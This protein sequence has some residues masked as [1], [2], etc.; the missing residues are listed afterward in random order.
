MRWTA[1][2]MVLVVVGSCGGCLDFLHREKT[3]PHTPTSATPAGEPYPEL[4]ALM[5]VYI[6]GIPTAGEPL[7]VSLTITN[8][9]TIPI[10]RERVVITVRVLELKSK[11]ANLLLRA[12]SAE[13]KTRRYTLDT[14]SLIEP[15]ESA[16]LKKSVLIPAKIRGMSLAGRY[17]VE[18]VLYVGAEGTGLKRVHSRTMEL[19]LT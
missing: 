10:I 3:I 4:K 11:R 7:N 14:S 6:E 13:Q 8:V 16:V 1:L 19:E 15:N 17:G 12:L 18:M 9:G 2:L 5:D